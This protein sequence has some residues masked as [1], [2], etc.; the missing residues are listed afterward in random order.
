MQKNIFRIV[1]VV[2]LILLI[3]LFGNIFV[4]GWNW[5]FF[6]FI[7][8]GALLFLTGLAIDFAIRKI[9]NPLHRVIAVVAIVLALILIWV[10]LAVDAVSQ[11]AEYLF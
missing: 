6:D 9:N 5:G 4:E 10:E 1:A 7:V 8:M 3:P 2:G 11:L